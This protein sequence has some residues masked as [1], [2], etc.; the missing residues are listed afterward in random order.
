[1]GAAPEDRM[2]PAVRVLALAAA[3][4]AAWLY[5]GGLGQALIQH[6]NEAMYAAPPVRMLA[7]GD[8][9]VPQWENRDFLDKPPLTFWVLAAGYRALGVSV[10]AAKLP[11]A[12]AG[13][14][15]ALFLGVWVGRRSGAQTGALAGLILAFS[16]Q[17]SVVALTFAADTFLTLALA[18]S[19]F[20]LDA[21]CR[22]Q[23]GSDAA[24]GAIAGAAL[25]A[26]F[27]CKG[28]VGVALPAGAVAVG[29]LLDR[30]RPV[31]PLRRGV[32]ALAALLV[33]VVPWHVALSQRLG[34][35]FWRTFYWE[36]QFLRGATPKFMQK[37]RGPFYYFGVLAWGLF[38]WSLQLPG[39]LRRGRARS[40]VLLGWFVFGFVFWSLLV[41]KREVYLA[42]ILPAAAALAA[43]GLVRSD[44]GGV[45]WRRFAWIGAGAIASGAIVFWARSFARFAALAESRG[46]ALF[47]GVG[48]AALG[49]AS[50]AA[51]LRPAAPRALFAVALGGGVLLLALQSF[52]ARLARFDP[53]PD[54]GARVRSE[55]AG[56][57]D[58]F[59]FA[60]NFNSID[61]YSGF[62][63]T[64]VAD[65]ARELPERLTHEKGFLV[66]WTNLES[67]LEGLP[68]R[69]EVLDR[70]PAFR[71][72]PMS[73]ALGVPGEGV[74]SMSLIR[75]R[76]P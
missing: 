64:F 17:F 53:L 49:A 15:T 29:L 58:G 50:V 62:D 59:L 47:L 45:R 31:R 55:C 41:M 2:D 73:A 3:A 22:R 30:A 44:A 54:W 76:R 37:T 70:R 75:L 21:A 25:A 69:W 27:Y 67:R 74:E 56:G 63:W 57:C 46:A 18:V 4:I 52:E 24:R 38:P 35:Q 43:E 5:L 61:F 51:A 12:L 60:N 1:M 23:D 72:G 7:S 68:L 14:A 32:W 48:L 6:G 19:I 39:V 11:G 8:Y 34:A 33:L 13:L 26:A 36:N 20:A 71:H 28:L 9:L 40:S 42:T 10:F 16:F 65:P 66:T